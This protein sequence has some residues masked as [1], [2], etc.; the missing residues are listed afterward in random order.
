[1]LNRSLV[2]LWEDMDTN[3]NCVKSNL[4]YRNRVSRGLPVYILYPVIHTLIIE[5]CSLVMNIWEIIF[6]DGLIK[7]CF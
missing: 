3:Y 7:L 5:H 6:L 4:S 2:V 1:M